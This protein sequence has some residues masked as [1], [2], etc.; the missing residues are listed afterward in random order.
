VPDW[1]RLV[2]LAGALVC[3]ALG[4][5]D[6]FADDLPWWRWVGE[7]LAGCT[8]F[9]LAL[10]R[11]EPPA[12]P[13]V[14]R[15]ARRAAMAA[16]LGAAALAVHLFPQPGREVA[17]AAAIAVAL[18][19]FFIARWVPFDPDDVRALL[20]DP[21][22]SAERRPSL[23]VT[24]TSLALAAISAAVAAAVVNP[25]HHAAA[26]CLWLASLGLFAAALWQRGG[27]EGEDG[28]TR[29]WAGQGGPQLSRGAEVVALTL[30]IVL[31]L[32][33]RVTFLKDV[34][35]VV[36]PDEGRQGRHAERIWKEGFP[37]AFD[38][39]WNVFPNLSYMVEYGWVQLRGTSNAN[40]RLSAATIGTLSVLP[41]F[42][43]VRRWWGSAI[44]LMAVFLLAI[45]REHIVWSRIAL[46]NIQQVL[47]AGLML[48]A[49]ARVLRSRRW[50]DWV[51]FG[52]ATGLAFHTYH[53][54]KLFPAL[55]AAAA[56]LLGLGIRRFIRR[57]AAGAAI[58][59]LA[60][61]LCLGPLLVTMHNKWEGFYGGT[62]N[63][64]DLARLSELY[65][66]GNV[67]ELR[68]FLW[69]HIGGC[70]FSFIS[71]PQP[72]DA[73]FD[74]FAAVPFLLGVGWML[75]RWRD[76][77]HLV[78]LV[79]T[80]GILVI[81]GMITDYPPWKARMLGFLP[82]ICVIPA[83]VAGRVR[84]ALSHWAPRRVDAMAAPALLLWLGAALHHNWRTE[85]VV[86][87]PLQRGD[88]MTETYRVIDRTPL[89]ATFYM[90]RGALVTELKLAMNDC[91]IAPHPERYLVNLPDDAAIVPIP[92]TN[93]GTAV[94]LVTLYQRELLPLIRHY[95]PD[96]QYEAA[97]DQLG[98]PTLHVFTLPER[99]I[100]RHRGLRA[101]YRS[102]SRTWS[103][104]EGTASFAP[105]AGADFPV[106]ATWR[107][108]VWIR[109][110]GTYAL[111][112]TGGA[113]RVDGTPL[114]D[115]GSCALAAGWHPIELSATFN[116]PADRVTLE[117]KPPGGPQ[118]ASIPRAF[119]D[120]HP[121]GHGLLGRYFAR[122]IT[123]SG[124][125]PI[126]EPADYE[127]VETAL[128]FDWQANLDDHPPEP[129]A[130]RPSTMEWT[131]TVDVPEGDTQTI[132]LE[133][134]TPARVFVGGALV[135]SAEGKREGQRVEVELTGLS[136]RV[137]IL[138]RT[139]RPAEDDWQYWKLRLLWR[140]AGGGWTAFVRYR[141]EAGVSDQPQTE[142]A[143]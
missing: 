85:F 112:T 79:W 77:R 28:A 124:P 4:Y 97:H 126:V 83:I 25:T 90:A 130:A 62:S 20:A 128:S 110:P 49:F 52:Y 81:G 140:D 121:E 18:G 108:Q 107:G 99:E 71:T 35:A 74:P 89:P 87:P 7:L 137:P 61:L 113:L 37:N 86:R 19:A 41:V 119:L 138:V 65:H 40:L 96:A 88:I 2:L 45:N 104:E 8:L 9:T 1:A 76:P 93:H 129:L 22:A 115:D 143:S 117:W 141:P 32:A 53:A 69:S 133:T 34:P 132:R 123:A 56:L 98:T 111:R 17:T 48:A 72:R 57:Y 29:R 63:R 36:D 14:R 101:T 23:T 42:F 118:W 38:I 39:G 11:E 120:T 135:L 59:A 100:E 64:F 44:A 58:G 43:W 21:A 6:H 142:A 102:A 75:W 95:Y 13:P 47:V 15:W 134:T 46:N 54:A 67:R 106:S 55:L 105:P 50:V 26:F 30:V 80:A 68:H 109:T 12:E 127:R 131:G 136:G 27:G 78:V 24:R 94:L 73:I 116:Q 84:E 82:A 33:L 114:P 91:M 16:A 125:D 139:V 60:F 5:H 3:G 103:V 70:L 122:A 51:W 92:P 10:R 31:A 66:Q